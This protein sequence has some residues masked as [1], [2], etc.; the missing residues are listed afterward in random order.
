MKSAVVINSISCLFWIIPV[1]LTMDGF[2]M[3][4]YYLEC[5]DRRQAFDVGYFRQTFILWM[6]EIIPLYLVTMLY[7]SVTTTIWRTKP[8][9]GRFFMLTREALCCRANLWA[10]LLFVNNYP[11]T[12]EMCFVHT[13]YFAASAQ[14]FLGAVGTLWVMSR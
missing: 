14:L 9:V 2:T 4:V 6:I 1:F 10:N 8:S 13:W 11:V 7:S 5:R 3:M 12:Q